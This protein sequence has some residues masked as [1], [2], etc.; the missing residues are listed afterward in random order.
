MKVLKTDIG[1]KL[2]GKV[3]DSYPEN[4]RSKL[5]FLRDLILEV[6]SENEEMVCLETIK[7]GE[8]AYVVKN[9]STIRIAWNSKKPNQFA[10]YFSCQTN[11]V[12]T[13]RTVYGELFNFEGTR[14]IVFYEKDQLPIVELKQCILAALT[15]HSRKHKPFLGI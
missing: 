7:W 6:V 1:N 12:E 13:F 2:V 14:A 3:F 15:Y 4:F 8:P 11:L 9:G 5:L 10:I